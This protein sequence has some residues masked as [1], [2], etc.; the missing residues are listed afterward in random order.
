MD[1]D[2]Q[3]AENVDE[4]E[5][6]DFEEEQIEQ[7]DTSDEA[8]NLGD[9]YL[10][11]MTAGYM[12]EGSGYDATQE[13]LSKFY[14]G[15]TL[16]KELSSRENVVIKNDNN[17]DVYISTPGTTGVGDAVQTW[18]DIMS[19]GQQSLL[20][21]TTGFTGQ[22]IG[23]AGLMG[24]RQFTDRESYDERVQSTEDILDKIADKYGDTDTLLLGHSLGGA[25]TR[26]VALDN[27]LS[28]IIYN[29]AVGKNSI[30]QDNQKK[31]IELRIN[32]DIVSMTMRDKPREFSFDKG[33]SMFGS[34]QAHDLT[35]FI[36]NKDR[37]DNIMSGKL[38][39]QKH[40]PLDYSKLVTM[41]P[42]KYKNPDAFMDFYERKC[43]RGFRYN[44]D[45]KACEKY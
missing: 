27:N 15:L 41:P 36:L 1:D 11:I 31:N 32:K 8:K 9:Q 13:Y 3:E 40:H 35:N 24:A 17:T 23:R 42:K 21:L 20:N 16:D 28:S 19:E 14:D 10:P 39:L 29:S 38:T 45:K 2:E 33:Y 12:F 6:L 22:L 30:Y 44:S 25:I 18:G 26:R 7:I 4:L 5:E 43:P 34:I 37:Y